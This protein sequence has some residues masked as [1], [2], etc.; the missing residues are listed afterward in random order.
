[1]KGGISGTMRTRDLKVDV[2]D[3]VT[4][5]Q[6][7]ETSAVRDMVRLYGARIHGFLRCL[8]RSDETAEELTQEVLIR[9][10]RKCGHVNSPARFESWLFTLARNIAIKEMSRSRYRKE[11]SKEISWFDT[12]IGSEN[13]HPLEKISAEQSALLLR[14]ALATLDGKRREIMALRYFSD[15]SLKEISHVM[16]IPIGSIGTTITRS[17]ESLKQYFDSRGIKVE[18]LL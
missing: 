1:M 7:G 18:D 9:I 11:S 4:R 8:V 10:Y 15:L 2:T 6:K 12:W 5:L 14:E 16:N 13:E 17:L 3:L